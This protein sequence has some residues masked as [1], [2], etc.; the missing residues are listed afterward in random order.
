MELCVNARSD[1]RYWF[2]PGMKK[3]EIA[4]FAGEGFPPGSTLMARGTNIPPRI[5]RAG[6]FV[7]GWEVEAWWVSS[8]EPV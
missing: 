4:E 2:L 5:F 6:K 3:W 7:Y 1:A 8:M